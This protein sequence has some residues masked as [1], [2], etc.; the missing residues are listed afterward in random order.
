MEALIQSDTGKKA[1]EETSG[2][3]H[4]HLTPLSWL[5]FPALNLCLLAMTGQKQT[6][7][8]KRKRKRNNE[9]VKR[10]GGEEERR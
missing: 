7:K 2:R 9:M 10:K 5:S 6:S 1:K 8:R 3:D 4:C